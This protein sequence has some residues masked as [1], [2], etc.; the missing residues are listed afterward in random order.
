MFDSIVVRRTN[1]VT[2]PAV[3]DLGRLAESMVFYQRVHLALSRA[4]LHQFIIGVG[5]DLAIELV[6]N[7]SIDAVFLDRDFAV[8]NENVGTAAER[9]RPVSINVMVAD[10][11]GN[12]QRVQNQ[13]DLVYQFFNEAMDGQPR[14]A[15]KKANRFLN[16]L[17]VHEFPGELQSMAASEWQ[18][19][20]FIREAVRLM[21]AELAPGYTPPADLRV[22]LVDAGDTFFHFE[23]NLDWD[24]IR[25][26]QTAATGVPSTLGPGGFLVLLTDLTADLH[27]G[28]SLNATLAQDQLGAELLR[29]KCADLRTTADLQQ[30]QIDSFQ[31]LVVH[32]VNDIAAVINSGARTFDE[33]LKIR[34]D[35]KP[36][37]NW[38]DGQP[39]DADLV[40]AYSAELAKKLELKEGPMGKL[41]W[42]LP[43][44]SDS[45]ALV[46]P[47]VA[48]VITAATIGYGVFDRFILERYVFG[49]RPS[50]FVDKKLRPFVE[51]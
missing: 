31:D 34:K 10:A 21:I 38:L 7:G 24:A 43:L 6:E 48:D 16:Q 28:A 27:L 51:G 44:A 12:A 35:A 46:V 15:R 50:S 8:K 1:P 17:R 5:P 32:G 40:K 47:P 18:N 20:V 42:M 4:G 39:A 25:A 22:A 45:T 11:A 13:Q 36:F 26:A 37:R 23:S 9:H 49:W 30:H 29:A 41:R 33:F 3:V 19:E 2:A 14:K